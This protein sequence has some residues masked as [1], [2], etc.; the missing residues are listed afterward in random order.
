[1]Q[2]PTLA[3]LAVL[4]F[5]ALLP[6]CAGTFDIPETRPDDFTMLVTVY[7]A[8]AR[9]E[10]AFRPARYAIE[11]DGLLRAESG[12]GVIRQ[13]FPPI[14]RRLEPA[15]I[16]RIY[17]L[18]RASGV[19]DESAVR[20]PGMTEYDPPADQAVTVLEIGSQGT[21]RAVELPTDPAGPIAPFI[22]ELARLSW[23]DR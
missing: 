15:Q 20:V 9:A 1:M 18:A 11:P 21:F 23:L 14:A 22:R 12:S 2:P 6:G 13:G 16:D 10:P 17:A 7:P 5:S 8:Q 19:L 4:L 3:L